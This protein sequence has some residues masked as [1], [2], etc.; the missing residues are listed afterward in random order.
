[1]GVPFILDFMELNNS[2]SIDNY[3]GREFGLLFRTMSLD[4]IQTIIITNTVQKPT[5]VRYLQKI[6]NPR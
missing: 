3:T 4:N 6:I 2:S 1:M 5:G